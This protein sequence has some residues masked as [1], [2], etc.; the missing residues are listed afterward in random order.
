MGVLV[1][2]IKLYAHILRV[3]GQATILTA[4]IITNKVNGRLKH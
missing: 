3:L 1:K 4:L 2:I